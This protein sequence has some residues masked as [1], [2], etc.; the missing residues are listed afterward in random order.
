MKQNPR[1]TV[2]ITT[3]NRMDLLKMM[4]K[5]FYASDLSNAVINVRI[6]D[7][8]STELNEIIIKDRFIRLWYF[9]TLI[10]KK[11]GL[12]SCLHLPEGINL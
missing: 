12:N 10:L 8:N 6:Y 1:I 9:K 2:G 4:A 5:S 11:F 3:Y 7:D